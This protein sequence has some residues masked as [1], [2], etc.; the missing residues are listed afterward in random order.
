MDFSQ[1]N[2]TQILSSFLVLLGI[3][4]IIG[5]VPI[6]IPLK[7]KGRDVSPVKA[8]LISFGLLDFST[9]VIGFWLCLDATSN[10]LP[11]QVPF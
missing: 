9:A 1:L 8:T 3:I 10:R 2:F 7:E 6:I 11:W 4:D 5:A